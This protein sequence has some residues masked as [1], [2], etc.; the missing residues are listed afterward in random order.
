MVSAYGISVIVTG[1]FSC[2]PIQFYWDKS[3]R[4]GRCIDALPWGVSNIALN[5]V[6][7]LAVVALP[8]HILKDLRLSRREKLAI[9][10][11]FLVGGL[12]VRNA[13][14]VVTVG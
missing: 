4:G 9:Q 3:I 2:Y 5:V 1:I 7:D 8:L 14:D 13:C 11:T 12:Y 10:G 6:T